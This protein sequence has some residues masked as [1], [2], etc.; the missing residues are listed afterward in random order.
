MKFPKINLQ[1]G[2][3]IVEYTY[4]SKFI[5]IMNM[6]ELKHIWKEQEKKIDRNWKLN[7]EMLRNTNLDKAE[8]KINSLTWITAITLSN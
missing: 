2:L 1:N 3:P 4:L 7:V 6:E 8:S 5:K